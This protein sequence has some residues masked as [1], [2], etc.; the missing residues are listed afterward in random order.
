MDINKTMLESKLMGITFPVDATISGPFKKNDKGVY[1]TE[2]S[3]KTGK[4]TRIPE[5]EKRVKYI[6][7]FNNAPLGFILENCAIPSIKIS[8]ATERNNG[9]KA[10]EALNGKIID[11]MEEMRTTRVSLT[12]MEQATRAFAKMT[13]AE[14]ADFL[15]AHK[16][17]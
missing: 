7:Q 17:K 3:T 6:I 14:Q 2:L 10:V 15:S 13:P 4:Q 8:V 12:P 9:E 11:V 1:L 16:I 5:W